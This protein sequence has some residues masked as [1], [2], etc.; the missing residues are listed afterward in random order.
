M[1]QVFKQVWDKASSKH[2]LQYIAQ[3]PS[4]DSA[5]TLARSLKKS[6]VKI[7]GS[8]CLDLR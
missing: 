6:V 7:N 5:T 2:V 3:Y 1:Y 4:L 8:I